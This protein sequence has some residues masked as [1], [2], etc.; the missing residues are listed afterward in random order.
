MT[1][2]KCKATPPADAIA[3]G[4]VQGKRDRLRVL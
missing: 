4:E 1:C 3:P 2:P